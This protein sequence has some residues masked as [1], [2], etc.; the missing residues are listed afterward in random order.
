MS[1]AAQD[2]P[3]AVN[4]STGGHEV[5]FVGTSMSPLFTSLDQ[6]R[7]EP[8]SFQEVHRGDILVFQH[9]SK[10]IQVVH[11]AVEVK[12]DYVRT[13][14][15]NLSA[16]DPYTLTELDQLH[17][18]VGVARG[19][20]LHSV[21]NGPK[22]FRY[23]RRRHR[24]LLLR[25]SIRRPLLLAVLGVH[26]IAPVLLQRI[27]RKH[28]RVVDKQVNGTTTQLL[29]LGKRPVGKRATSRSEWELNPPFDKI[30]STTHLP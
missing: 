10:P 1:E 4:S 29:L 17:R 23:A 19:G 13:R 5:R 15:D 25:R 30:L 8:I 11:R 3:H 12:D 26:A 6:L 9:P 21:L 16:P 2:S 22:G 18:V 24:I 28:L 20:T 27:L 14:G 7:I